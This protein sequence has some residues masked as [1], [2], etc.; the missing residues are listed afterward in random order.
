[1]WTVIIE[2]RRGYSK[3]PETMR[4]RGHLPAMAARHDLIVAEMTRR[5]YNHRS[6]LAHADRL[7]RGEVVFPST[8]AP[9]DDMRALLAA[10]Q[11]K[12]LS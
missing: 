3:H 1:M 8:I 6:P 10:K 2:A 9:I 7:A 11:Q 5:G 4:W 12:T